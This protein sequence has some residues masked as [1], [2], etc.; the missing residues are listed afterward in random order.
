MPSQVWGRDPQ[1][2]FENPYE[3]AVQEQFVREAKAL[4]KQ[5]YLLLAAD[6]HSYVTT[7]TSKEKAVWLL[8]MDALDSLRDALDALE[9]KRHRVAGKLFR[10]VMES[11]DLAAYFHS[12]SP[13]SATD[14]AK[15]YADE[16]VLH[17]RYREHVRKTDGPAAADLKRDQHRGLSKFVH[18]SYRAILDGYSL[19]G[20]ERL[21]YDGVGARFGDHKDADTMLVLPQTIASY[22]ASLADLVLV[23]LS[24]T[25]RRGTASEGDVSAALESSMEQETV[26]RRF[27]PRTWFRE[28]M[29][30][31]AEDERRVATVAAEPSASES[32]ARPVA[33]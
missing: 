18:R 8:H 10:S 32:D 28:M 27:M 23:F 25:V 12:G 3:Y 13:D 17:G 19:G 26:K 22:H 16:V 7:D 33:S 21:V 5:S 14:L 24:E 29:L 30:A 2:A 11:L 31:Q 15:W 20:G 1:E 4:F 9:R 6:S